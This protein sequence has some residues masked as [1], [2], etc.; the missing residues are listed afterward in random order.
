MNAKKLKLQYYTMAL[1]LSTLGI[2][3]TYLVSPYT[4]GDIIIGLEFALLSF[5]GSVYIAYYFSHVLEEDLEIID[6]IN[7]F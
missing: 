2:I 1:I 6:M 3:Y 7:K 4:K 5:S